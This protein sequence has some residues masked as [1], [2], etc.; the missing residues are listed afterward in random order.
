MQKE[1]QANFETLTSEEAEYFADAICGSL[2]KCVTNDVPEVDGSILFRKL[3]EHGV[4][5]KTA[6]MSLANDPSITAITIL[7]KVVGKPI[8]RLVPKAEPV[9]NSSRIRA[10][11]EPGAKP[12]LIKNDPRVIYDIIPNPKKMGSKSYERYEFY[13]EGM[14][15][16]EFIQ[17]G[18]TTG[19]I[20]HDVSKG[21]IKLKD[22]E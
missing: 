2:E 3:V 5:H 9:V 18:G 8:Q 7:E 11:L 4:D 16:M 12:K 14:T 17:A 20:Q 1:Y 19:D 15:V 6:C 10:Q 13:R 21:F 22:A